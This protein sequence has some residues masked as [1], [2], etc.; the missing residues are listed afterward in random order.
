MAGREI[1]SKRG[2]QAR[3]T[4]TAA[5]IPMVV[6]LIILGAIIGA[7]AGVF[8]GFISADGSSDET[9]Q[10]MTYMLIGTFAPGAVL[11]F[12]W[13]VFFERR[14]LAAIGLNG[15]FL[16]RFVRGYGLGLAFL[17]IVVGGIWLLGGYQIEASG[18]V[19]LAVLIPAAWVLLGFIVQGST[20]EIFMR[21]WLMGL[22][23]SRHGIVWGVVVNS[24]IFSLLHG[25]NIEMSA[26]LIFGLANILLVGVMLSF[27]AIKEGSL[28]GVCGWHAAWNWL[29]ASGFGLPVSGH[30]SPVN[31]ILIDLADAPDA[32]WWLTG[33]V[34]GPEASAVTTVVLLAGTLY[35][36]FK[37]KAADYGV[38]AP[39]DNPAQG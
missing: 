36:A 32:A 33:G 4:W 15:Q 2:P 39:T 34:F 13:V 24:A 38:E 31:P 9:W 37:G 35:W 16:G 10:G 19:A 25:A 8:L 27:Y 29:L 1:Y 17:T 23:T 21:G 20:E 12:L 3:R 26:E 7:V 11:I 30:D 18:S 6:V 22:I 5:A 14:P 28:W